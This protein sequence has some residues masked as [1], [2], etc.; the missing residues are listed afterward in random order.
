MR[1]TFLIFLSALMVGSIVVDGL[2]LQQSGGVLARRLH[3]FVDEGNDQV[4]VEEFVLEEV[5]TS[6]RELK[7]AATNKIGSRPPSCKGKCKGCVP[8]SP[9]EVTVPPAQH[10]SSSFTRG[11][12]PNGAFYH[13]DESPYYSVAWRCRCKGKDYNP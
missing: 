4:Y 3:K 8:C 5:H 11:P 9:V 7:V 12:F 6:R 10:R 13:L 1:G 2:L